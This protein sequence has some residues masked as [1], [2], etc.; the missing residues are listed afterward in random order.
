MTITQTIDIPV[1][2]R[3]TLVVPPQIPVGRT[4]VAFTPAPK[5]VPS[6]SLS[7]CK[8]MLTAEEEARD[9]E[10]YSLHAEEL[11]REAEDVLL[12]QVDIFEKGDPDF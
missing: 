4:I 2:R 8:V 7:A 11:N 6:E 12:Y 3:I 10:L 9:K 5:A 1:S